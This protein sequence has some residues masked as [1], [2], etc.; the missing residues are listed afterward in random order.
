MWNIIQGVLLLA[1]SSFVVAIWPLFPIRPSIMAITYGA[2]WNPLFVG[3]IASFG[4]TVAAAITYGLTYKA[5][6]LKKAKE[7]LDKK[8]VA[9][10]INKLRKRMFL[11]IVVI[12]GT[13]L[14]DAIVGVLGG[15]E[16]YPFKKFV[17]ANFLGRMAI[18]SATA[19][20]ANQYKAYFIMFWHWFLHFF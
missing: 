13:P 11:L 1:G 6:E 8:A 3:F 16:K 14:P 5:T 12:V 18:Y 17:F 7:F 15:M 10:L 19:F 9:W 20:F 2:I 4:G